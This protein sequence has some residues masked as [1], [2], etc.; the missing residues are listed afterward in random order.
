MSAHRGFT[1]T[2]SEN[3]DSQFIFPEKKLIN[4]NFPQSSFDA[5]RR[6]SVCSNFWQAYHPERKIVVGDDVLQ[7]IALI[8]RVI[9]FRAKPANM[10][11]VHFL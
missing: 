2:E 7:D 8:E 10:F 5:T 4:T 6:P 11:M 1:L 3:S 9:L